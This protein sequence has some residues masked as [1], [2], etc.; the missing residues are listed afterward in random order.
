MTAALLLAALVVPS[1]G[2]TAGVFA[3]PAIADPVESSSGM[4]NGYDYTLRVND[5]RLI[6]DASPGDGKCET[7][8]N[9][10]ATCTLLAAAQEANALSAA[11]PST[12]V[13]ITLAA[14]TPQGSIRQLNGSFANG[15]TVLLEN[16]AINTPTGFVGMIRGATDM[17]SIVGGT[18]DSDHDGSI[19][20]FAGNVVVD[21][22]NRLELLPPGDGGM[23]GVVMSFT[24]QDQVLRNFSNVAG[25]EGAIYVGKTAKNLLIEKGRIA[26]GPAGSGGLTYAIER[27]INVVGVQKPR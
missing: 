11:T 26:N 19:L 1:V 10:G 27:A 3:T 2:E 8:T 14:P 5:V 13:L 7:A 18:V 16:S 6:P 21:L 15:G 22:Q 12:K 24:G 25:A 17:N 4:H 9:Y 20:W 23:T